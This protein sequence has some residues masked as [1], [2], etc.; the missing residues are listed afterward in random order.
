MGN[1]LFCEYLCSKRNP[2]FLNRSLARSLQLNQRELEQAPPDRD[3]RSDFEINRADW[4]MPDEENLDAMVA[5]QESNRS[6]I[7][8]INGI[9]PLKPD[10]R[11]QGIPSK[12]KAVLF[13]LVVEVHITI[14]DPDRNDP[15]YRISN[16]EVAMLAMQTENGRDIK[17]AMPK[18]V[19]KLKD[20]LRSNGLGEEPSRRLSRPKPWNLLIAI[21]FGGQKDAEQFFANMAPSHPSFQQNAPSRMVM[22]WIDILK[23]PGVNTV[24]PLIV[25]DE[26]LDF[27]LKMSLYWTPPKDESVLAMHN[28]QLKSSVRAAQYPTP[29]LEP[30]PSG[31]NFEITFVYQ[32]T[33]FTREGLVCPHCSRSGFYELDALRMHLEAWHDMFKYRVK[34][35]RE[36]GGIQFWK[37]SCDV[38]DHKADQQRASDR[39]PDPREIQMLAPKNPFDRQRYLEGNKDFQKA[40]RLEKIYRPAALQRS[41]TAQLREKIKPRNPDEVQERPRV[42]GRKTYKVPKAPTSITFFR[43]ITKRPLQEGEE[44]SESDDEVDM[45]WVRL[46]KEAHMDLDSG[47]PEPTKRFLKAFD[48]FLIDERLQGD[49]HAAD[50]LIRFA[51]AKANW[52][53]Q[54]KLLDEFQTKADELL[55]D[56]II[57][58]EVHRASLDIVNKELDILSE[59][60]AGLD[61]RMNRCPNP[62][63][64]TKDKGKGKAKV[65]ATGIMTPQT[66]DSDGDVEMQ[67]VPANTK[68]LEPPYDQCLCGEDALAASITSR[69]I[70]CENIV[71]LM[72]F[73]NGMIESITNIR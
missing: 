28:R 66:A 5:N 6:L 61:A 64:T 2:P 29:P 48:S 21:N 31:H 25:R 36:E 27:G 49:I 72:Q 56:K 14:F 73:C 52:L 53:Q 20:L 42:Q 47:I 65:T 51:R 44:I 17:L 12:K 32:D 50:A 59:Q 68:P 10:K 54:Q 57:T 40:A 8:H 9:E 67:D 18:S 19:I 41:T 33:S 26:Q 30:G 34:K 45:D 16:T 46:K 37:F 63:L 58:E 23:C 62:S 7:V 3:S 71:S 22:R 39:A 55:G 4:K 35:E 60:L 24:Q 70:V 43:S 15:C 13:R 69:I 11:S 1:I 38:A